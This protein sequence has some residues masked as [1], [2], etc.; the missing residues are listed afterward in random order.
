MNDDLL[1]PDC[2]RSIRTSEWAVAVGK[3]N[4]ESVIVLFPDWLC[5]E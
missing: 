5:P 1:L 3:T 4:H 2:H